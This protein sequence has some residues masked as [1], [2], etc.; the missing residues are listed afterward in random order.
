MWRHLL[1]V[2]VTSFYI[3]CPDCQL[4]PNLTYKTVYF[5]L[6]TSISAPKM[7]NRKNMF[8]K[9]NKTKQKKK[10]PRPRKTYSI[11]GSKAKPDIPEGNERKRKLDTRPPEQVAKTP[12]IEESSSSDEEEPEDAIKQLRASFGGGFLKKAVSAIE[13]SSDSEFDD[14]QVE[15]AVEEK[16]ESE[17]DTIV[18]SE[19]EDDGGDDEEEEEETVN[20]MFAEHLFY[21][22]SESMLNNLQSS[23]V[24]AENITESW[25]CLGRLS[26]QLP[27]SAEEP[28]NNKT[29]INIS[30]EHKKASPGK[31][32]TILKNKERISAIKIQIR[33]NVTRKGDFTPLQN[34]IFSA[35]NNY[36]DFFYPQ[37]SF[38][39][40]EQIR[41][42]YCVHAVNH[43]LKTRMR[44]LHHNAR[45]NKRDGDVP[46]EFRDQGLVRPKVR[47]CPF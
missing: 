25:P 43:V 30:G 28:Q 20:D 18:E 17:G 11:Y 1:H 22:L 7:V 33:N 9:R 41:F 31:P 14:E 23:P 4:S 27:K 46:E 13:S 36:Q 19:I 44:V 29:T 15:G 8:K 32:P 40:A 45:L 5:C 16:G 3:G 10:Q 2:T 47:F 12:K 24:V 37:R 34:E 42:V 39:N 21:D 38:S 6:L 26:I 35:L